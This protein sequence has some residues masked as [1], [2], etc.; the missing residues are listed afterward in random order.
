M[1]LSFIT[2]KRLRRLVAQGVEELRDDILEQMQLQI[3][4]T[5]PA[6]CP[7]CGCNGVP[8]HVGIMNYTCG[9]AL[10]PSGF[11]SSLRCRTRTDEVYQDAKGIK[12]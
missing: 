9:S 7:G 4:R 2:R 1:M 10:G 5:R 3:E 6:T 11:N 12:L 8:I